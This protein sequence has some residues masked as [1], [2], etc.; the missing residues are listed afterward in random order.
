MAATKQ[1]LIELPIEIADQLEQKAAEAKVPL[2]VIVG[3]QLIRWVLGNH[4][5]SYALRT[6]RAKAGMASD[7]TITLGAGAL[8]AEAAELNAQRHLEEQGIMICSMEEDYGTVCVP[9]EMLPAEIE[10]KL[11]AE[12]LTR[13]GPGW[14]VSPDK[15]FQNGSPHPCICNHH[16][17]RLHYLLLIAVD[18]L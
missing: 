6:A 8:A 10:Q 16:P 17:D 11:D 15:T 9:K 4:Q 5:I 3:G 12:S 1:L 7:R 13:T 18:A 14:K 2:Q